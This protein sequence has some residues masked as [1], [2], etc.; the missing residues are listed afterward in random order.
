MGRTTAFLWKEN[1]ASILEVNRF[2]RDQM[3]YTLPK[4]TWCLVDSMD[5]PDCIFLTCRF[6]LQASS[7]RIE[8]M[9]W[10]NKAEAGGMRAYFVMKPWS[11]GE[12]IAG[13]QLQEWPHDNADRRDAQELLRKIRRVC[14]RCLCLCRGT[15][16]FR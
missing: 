13:N 12:L 9:Q 5:V 7:T 4:T 14:A 3:N 16:S 2:N 11:L 10:L 15:I 6:V 1:E 8:E